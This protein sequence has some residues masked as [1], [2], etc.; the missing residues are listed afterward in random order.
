MRKIKWGIIGL[1]DIA[2]SFA[3]NFSVENAELVA[4]G[5][6]NLQKAQDFAEKHA[7][8]KAYGSYEGCFYDPDID[9]IYIAT[10]NSFHYEHILAA[11][12]QKKHV[13]SEKAMMV[14]YSEF[15]E[16]IN[17]AKE[18]NVL[19]AEAM[20]IYHMP[21]YQLLKK[22]IQQNDFGKLKMVHALFGSYKPADENNRFFNPDL[23]G[24]ALLDIGVYALSF[25]RYF[26]S[27]NPDILS[28]TVDL[29]PTGV[30]EQSSTLLKNKENEVGTLSLSFR[31][32][33]PKQGVIVCEDAYIT[34]TDY[35]RADKAT[36][37]YS[38]G[39]SETITAGDTKEAMKY[40]IQAF[41]DAVAND[42]SGP[43][44]DLTEDVTKIMD[45]LSREWD[46][47]LS[48][49]KPF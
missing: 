41:T 5:S 12:K 18:N 42:S 45:T 39:K 10:P 24:G 27:S 1:G 4:V 26:M 23:G 15:T 11:L 43:Y 47:N 25:I 32:K 46:M 14:N 3:E 30:D 8:P 49:H 33:M 28:T 22:K 34:I 48:K 16:A 40:E 38:N 6:R 20:T 7:I 17:C 21:L 36:I 31:A 9:V 35:P 29:Y 13:F 37:T 44:M 2:H 19:L